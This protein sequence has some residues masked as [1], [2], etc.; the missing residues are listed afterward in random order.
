MRKFIFPL[1]HTL[2]IFLPFY[3]IFVTLNF[4][5]HKYTITELSKDQIILE[6]GILHHQNVLHIPPDDEVELVALLI[7]DTLQKM[8]TFIIVISLLLSHV[9]TLVLTYFL[10]KREE[11]ETYFISL[12]L[13]LPIVIIYLVLYYSEVSTIE[14]FIALWRQ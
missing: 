8:E 14:S 7:N 10:N 3:F 11:K 12:L 1:L 2:I 9:I 5:P 13:L 6:T 4:F